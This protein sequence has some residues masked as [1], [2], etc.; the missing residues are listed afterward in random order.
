[1]RGT[2][3]ENSFHKR[4]VL[5]ANECKYL[6]LFTVSNNSGLIMSLSYLIYYRPRTG[7]D[8]KLPTHPRACYHHPLYR[9]HPRHGWTRV[10]QHSRANDGRW[11]DL[12]MFLRCFYEFLKMCVLFASECSLTTLIIL[13]HI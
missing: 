6:I 4:T 9:Q 12:N 7:S 1:M 8:A 5:Y 2:I 10:P 11:L 13:H 3:F